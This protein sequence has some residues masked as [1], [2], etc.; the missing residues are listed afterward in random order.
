MKISPELM[1]RLRAVIEEIFD[2]NLIRVSSMKDLGGSSSLTSLLTTTTKTPLKTLLL[3]TYLKSQEGKNNFNEPAVISVPTQELRIMQFT[4]FY[5]VY[6]KHVGVGA[7]RKAFEKAMKKAT[8]EVILAG[9]NR[10]AKECVDKEKRF[11]CLPATWLNQERWSDEDNISILMQPQNKEQTIELIKKYD[12]FI[13]RAEADNDPGRARKLRE[14]RA[15]LTLRLSAHKDLGVEDTYA[16][17]PPS[18]THHD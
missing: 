18:D 17:P 1:H 8:F 2:A 7:A 5:G 6:P 15:E 9:A 13:V 3:L 14:A 12:G 16:A 11:I 4:Q 10:Y